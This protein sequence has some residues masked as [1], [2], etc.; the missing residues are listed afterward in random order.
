VPSGYDESRRWDCS[1]LYLVHGG[2][3]N[4]SAWVWHGKI[5][6]ISD[7]LLAEKQCRKMLVVVNCLYYLNGDPDWASVYC[8]YLSRMP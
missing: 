3:E 8:L 6:F 7:N 2:R 4:E 1:V 5:Q